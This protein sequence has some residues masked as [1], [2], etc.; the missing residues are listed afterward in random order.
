MRFIK[1]FGVSPMEESTVIS[2]IYATF[3]LV[4]II[5]TYGYEL[6]GRIH[7]KFQQELK[8]S[9]R[10]I[11]IG[12]I[13]TTAAVAANLIITLVPICLGDKLRLR[14]MQQI[15]NID[16]ILKKHVQIRAN[17][18]K[19]YL[20]QQID[21]IDDILKKHVQIRANLKKF[22]LYTAILHL[23]YIGLLINDFSVWFRPHNA[24]THSFI[25]YVWDELFRYRISVLVLS[26]YYFLRELYQ[27]VSLINEI[28]GDAFKNVRPIELD[29]S[30]KI[31]RLENVVR[32]VSEFHASFMQ[33]PN[34]CSSL[35]GWQIFFIL[36]N[37]I[38]FFAMAYEMGLRIVT[39]SVD[40]V[41]YH[42]S[43][44]IVL[45]MIYRISI[46]VLYLY[47]F[48]R[49][50]YQKI[51]GMNT[52]LVDAFEHTSPEDLQI[53]EIVSNLEVLVDAF[54][55]TSPEDLQ[56][57]EIVSNLEKICEETSSFHISFKLI[58]DNFNKLFGWQL[59]LILLNYIFLF[60]MAY[61]LGLRIMTYKTVDV[62]YHMS[63]WII[64]CMI[65]ALKICS[66]EKITI[67]EKDKK[68]RE[69]MER[70]SAR[71]RTREYGDSLKTK[72][73]NRIQWKTNTK[74]WAK[75]NNKSKRMTMV[76]TH[77]NNAKTMVGTHLNNAK[78]QNSG[79]NDMK[80]IRI[81]EYD[82][83]TKE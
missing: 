12:L 57:P 59:L 67:E 21:N 18:K 77:L 36:L 7:T 39:H 6:H 27:K 41:T 47:Y 10:S 75:R 23:Y 42:L 79:E 58:V 83:K 74:F 52:V 2:K 81:E 3:I 35:F 82:K 53:P 16:D 24:K 46:L 60:M 33:I 15:D 66:M 1:L 55:H 19:F 44:W 14:L 13:N 45:C 49:H 9:N 76:G 22:Y 40:S 20:M 43:L 63:I 38:V 54:E 51:R 61:E 56:I 48:V 31:A 65:Y 25:F 4:L 17:L 34:D 28:L 70:D 80:K 69:K 5:F 78:A 71:R 50:L 30:E 11:Y 26:I 32:D 37:Y 29:G 62:T 8:P 64:A 72:I 68:T 73:E